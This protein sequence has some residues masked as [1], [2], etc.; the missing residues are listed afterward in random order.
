MDFKCFFGI[1][2]FDWKWGSCMGYNLC[3]MSDFQNALIS[4]I[5]GVFSSCF[6]LQRTTLNELENKFWHVFGILIFDIN[7]W[8]C[9]GY[10]LCIM[11]DFRNALIFGIFGVFSIYFL[12][13]TTLNDLW[14]RFWL[15]FWNFNFWQSDDFA[16]ALAFAW[17]PI[18]K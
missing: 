16:W 9:M 15:F 2:I 6:F 12:H 8:F 14:N 17:W 4:P 3:I 10:S 18:F 5:F 13:R 11:A 7:W 1:L